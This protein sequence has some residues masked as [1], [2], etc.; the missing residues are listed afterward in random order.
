MIPRDEAIKAT[1][2]LFELCCQQM[3]CPSCPSLVKTFFV[4]EQGYKTC[5]LHEE[6]CA[7]NR[8]WNEGE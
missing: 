1:K 7:W 8:F 4:P 3:D 2:L 5:G 6:P